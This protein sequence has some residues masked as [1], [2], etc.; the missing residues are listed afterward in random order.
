MHQVRKALNDIGKSFEDG[1]AEKAEL[2]LHW[3][4]KMIDEPTSRQKLWSWYR[5][6]ID[7]E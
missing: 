3:L 4:R 2:Q 5:E 7:E 1:N 6:L